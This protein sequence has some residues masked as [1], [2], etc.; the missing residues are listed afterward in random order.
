[1]LKATFMTAQNGTIVVD[2]EGGAQWIMRNEQD[3]ANATQFVDF[4]NLYFSSSMDF[5][6]E[7]GFPFAS[8]AWD[9]FHRGLEI[10]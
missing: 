6:D 4:S 7:Y 10:A 1:M 3:V 2:T 8:A 5:A 9:M